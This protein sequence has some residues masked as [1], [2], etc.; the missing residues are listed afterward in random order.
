MDSGSSQ[1]H[2]AIQVVIAEKRAEKDAVTQLW[3]PRQAVSVRF[4]EGNNGSS[5]D[6]GRVVVNSPS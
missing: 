3:L 4:Q 6:F 1:G 2:V 5:G